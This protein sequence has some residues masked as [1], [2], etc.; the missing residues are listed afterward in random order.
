MGENGGSGAVRVT[1]CFGDFDAVFSA[2]EEVP[3]CARSCASSVVVV[4]VVV[5]VGKHHLAPVCMCVQR[6]R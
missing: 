3:E 5:V 6:F 4:V 2:L 1:C